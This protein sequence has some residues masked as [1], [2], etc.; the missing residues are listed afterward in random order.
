MPREQFLLTDEQYA[1]RYEVTLFTIVLLVYLAVLWI[2]GYFY[3]HN[4]YQKRYL[5]ATNNT[6]Q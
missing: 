1:E 5:N 6:S 4:E 3:I 2:S